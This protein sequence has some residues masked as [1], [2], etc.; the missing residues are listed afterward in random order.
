[1]KKYLLAATLLLLTTALPA[2]GRERVSGW[3][4]QGGND[5]TVGGLTSTED[6]QESFA[7][8]TITVYD[9]GTLDIASIFSDDSGTV[10]AN[11]FTASATGFWFFLADDARYDL[12]F[13]GGGISTPFTIGDI[14][15]DDTKTDVTVSVASSATP[16]FDASLGS[17]F[18]NT[19]TANITSSTISNPFT[20]Q[21]ITI[22]FAQDGT[23]GWTVAWPANVQLRKAGYVVSSDAS[24][25]SV[26]KLYYDGTNWREIGRDADEVGY[27][28]EPES[29][30]LD[31]LG[32]LTIDG[33]FTVDTTGRDLCASGARCD[34][35]LEEVMVGI[36][37][38]VH[39]IDGN[40]YAKTEA[41]INAAIAAAQTDA[42][43]VYI[44][45]GS[46][47]TT[48][49]FDIDCTASNP[50]TV[51]GDGPQQTIIE[52][53]TWGQAVFEIRDCIGVQIRDIGF[54]NTQTKVVISGTYDG[55]PARGFAAG[56]YVA[57]SDKTVIE[58]IECIDLSNCVTWRGD[59]TSTSVLD[60]DNV[61]RGM[62]A[63]GVD[64]GL[65][66]QQQ[67]GCIVSDLIGEDIEVVQTGN[68][69][70]L[71]YFTAGTSTVDQ[72]SC[73]GSNFSDRDNLGGAA[74]KFVDVKG[75]QFTAM[76]GIGGESA[77]DLEANESTFSG[78]TFLDYTPDTSRGLYNITNTT[79]TTLSD[80]Y[81]STTNDFDQDGL[82]IHTAGNSDIRIVNFYIK[83]DYSSG[84]SGKACFRVNQGDR[85]QIINPTCEQ[86]D[87]DKLC[88]WIQ[89][90]DGHLISDPV[91]LGNV[92]S[93]R[94]FSL[95][96]STTTRIILHSDEIN[97][98]DLPTASI[99]DGSS[100][101]CADCTIANICVASGSGSFAKRLNSSWNCGGGVTIANPLEGSLT[102]Q[103]RWILKIVDHTDMT[104]VATA[105]TF[106]LWTLP[107]NTMIYDVVATVVTAWAGTGPVSAA[108]ASVGTT[109]SPNDLALDDNFFATGTRYD[110]HDATASGG[111]GAL[112]FDATD[113]FAPHM[114]VVGGAIE[115]QMDLTGG[116]HS[117]TS[118]GQA[119]IYILV[120]QPLGN[121]TTEAN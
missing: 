84:A 29:G 69:S 76:G 53:T 20:G 116:N 85:I 111:K 59:T 82:R 101:F 39:A 23:G 2:H 4:E 9:V 81:A 31:V 47:T 30:T 36:S 87:G 110:L 25:V 14:L 104:A 22:Y 13:S 113:K 60:E 75:F 15:L 34:A 43:A 32:A 52:Q 33:N 1:M 37:N 71:I 28:V 109:G 114:Y 66:A 100:M 35:F 90:G 38:N 80:F 98:A 24:A 18:T 64:Q 56:I 94:F 44:P 27:V 99:L 118:A 106:T 97:Q 42:S 115:L 40:L 77:F 26:I 57:D 68:P 17:I 120:S 74:Y 12:R 50:I 70:H 73:S 83:C 48:D 93:P 67:R 86:V 79:R 3:C 65:L 96:A 49:E 105:A 41:G 46:Y 88:F 95:T 102:N 19:L 45:A 51:F 61:L 11:P 103:P 16:I 10:K 63:K 8:C 117:T 91:F 119:R 108:V 72:E 5:V 55:N 54:L 121:T 58:N 78:G 62:K 112:L 7:S 89:D 21:R 92:T 107:T 6:V